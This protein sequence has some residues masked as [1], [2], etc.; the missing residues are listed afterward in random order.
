MHD[1]HMK[2]KTKAIEH[3]NPPEQWTHIKTSGI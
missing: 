3:A 1:E 2:G